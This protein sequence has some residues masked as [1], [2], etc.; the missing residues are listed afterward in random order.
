M[1]LNI[2]VAPARSKHRYALVLFALFGSLPSACV[3]DSKDRCGPH[4]VMYQDLRC[5]C[6]MQ[7]ATTATGC[8]P[9]GAHEIPGATGCVCEAGYTKP[10]GGVCEPAPMGLGTEC[11]DST[12]CTDAAYP[13]CEVGTDAKGY[14]TNNCASPADCTGGYACDAAASICRRP[15]VGLGKSCTSDADCA[16]TEAT[17]CDTFQSHSCLVQGCSL[18][19]DNCFTGMECCD[20]SAFGVAQPLCIPQGACST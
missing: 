17:Y 9:C 11:V 16:G 12:Q 3:Y 8:E 20:L 18:A 13:H 5:V 2:G 7:S 4:Q 15:P 14:C 10:E 19:P 1:N 6:D